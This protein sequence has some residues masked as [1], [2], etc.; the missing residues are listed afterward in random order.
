[1][2][3]SKEEQH[4]VLCQCEMQSP[5]SLWSHRASDMEEVPFGHLP[6]KCSTVQ[7]GAFTIHSKRKKK[8]ASLNFP[9]IRL[10]LIHYG[11]MVPR[12][13][14]VNSLENVL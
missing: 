14:P 10:C 8:K 7:S 3:S 11:I 5:R 12:F 13:S 1:M 2:T 4:N 9:Q 6:M